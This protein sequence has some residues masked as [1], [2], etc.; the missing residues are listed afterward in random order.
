MWLFH[1]LTFTSL[2]ISPFPV[3]SKSAHLLEEGI[4][5]HTVAEQKVSYSHVAF[6]GPQSVLSPAGPLFKQCRSSRWSTSV[7]APSLAG[8]V[9]LHLLYDGHISWG[10][11]FLRVLL[12]S[13]IIS[14]GLPAE[15]VCWWRTL[16][17]SRFSS[18]QHDSELQTSI[19][20]LNR[21]LSHLVSQ[22][23][24]ASWVHSFFISRWHLSDEGIQCTCGNWPSVLEQQCVD[25]TF[26]SVFF[27]CTSGTSWPWFKRWR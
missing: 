21:V 17:T 7:T 23:H 26:D 5:Q 11:G 14:P 1:L 22:M 16:S 13:I 9:R 18:F 8:S 10:H 25:L 4:H 2:I 12:Q 3:C 20:S 15:T 6:R 24:P 19:L 27:V